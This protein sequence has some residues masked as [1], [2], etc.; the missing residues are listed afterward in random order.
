MKR[1]ENRS[2][3]RTTKPRIFPV[4]RFLAFNHS[5]SSGE[6]NSIFPSPSSSV[7]L[8]LVEGHQDEQ[9]GE[10]NHRGE[11]DPPG[12]DAR[13]DTDDPQAAPEQKDSQEKRPVEI[14]EPGHSEQRGGEAHRDEGE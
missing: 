8:D 9:R 7:G 14:P 5:G 3:P 6:L 10:V 1:I 13:T 12:I 2:S 11:D 4:R